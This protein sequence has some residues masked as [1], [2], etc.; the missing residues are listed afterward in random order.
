MATGAMTISHTL[1]FRHNKMF[2]DSNKT[3]YEGSGVV[4]H[5]GLQ[6]EL[7]APE[8]TILALLKDNLSTMKMLDIGVGAGRTT[9]YFGE[10]V[11]EYTAV[12]YSENM[13]KACE[14]RFGTSSDRMS[15]RVCDVRSMEMF[16]SNYFDFVLFSYNGIDSICHEDR[17]KA[18]REIRRVCKDG[19]LFLFSSHNLQSVD[20]LFAVQKSAFVR[21]L[22]GKLIRNPL[23]VL[24]ND[25][26]EELHKRDF[27]LLRDGTHWFRL[28]NYYIK[29]KVQI[30]Q[31]E[32]LGFKNIRVF[33]LGGEELCDLPRLQDGITDHW[34]Y[35]LCVAS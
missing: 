34:L 32:E 8:K 25:S 13:I 27:A 12:D 31:I 14:Q 26:F 16:S 2:F 28:E 1:R 21:T 35:Y 4:R 33:T 29:P 17:L 3:A 22:Y 5:Y 6:N 30:H 23:L 9:A 24:L 20:Q 10:L 18:F 7:Q 15:F 11:A 19:G